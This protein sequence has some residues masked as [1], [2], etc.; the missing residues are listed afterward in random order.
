MKAN[1]PGALLVAPSADCRTS[2]LLDRQA[3]PCWGG[4]SFR[5][6]VLKFL[7]SGMACQKSRFILLMIFILPD[8]RHL[9]FRFL[10]KY[11]DI[12]ITVPYIY[13]S[14]CS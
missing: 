5:T 12:T 2:E 1:P 13:A 7:F 6:F 10:H 11:G 14:F 9:R 3:G 8:K 4:M